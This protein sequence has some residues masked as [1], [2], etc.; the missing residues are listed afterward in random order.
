MLYNAPR[1]T[2]DI[3]PDE[4]R[5]WQYV[6]DKFRSVCDRFAYEEIRIPTFEHTEV[7]LR[8][9]GETTDVVQKEMYT[10]DDKSGR[11][12]TLR[13]EGTA[14]VAR[15]FIEQGMSSN[16]YPVR[17]YYLL[18]LFRYE[19]VGKGRYREFNQFGV[20][21]FGSG[22]PDMDAEVIALADLF[23]AELG[24]K[25]RLHINSIGCPE[26][27]GEYQKLLYEYYL[28]H[29]AELCPDC[30]QRLER[31]PLRLIDC[32]VESCR[33]ISRS[34]PRLLDYLDE[35]CRAHFDRVLEF[36]RSL[37]IEY[38]IDKD[39]V[40]GLDYYTKTVF[41]FVS[42][43]VGTQGTICGGGRY[44][45]LI[46]TMGGEEVPGVGFALGVER[47]LMELEAQGCLPELAQYPDLFIA[48]Q[49]E[50]AGAAAAGLALE[51]RRRG[52]RV[53]SEVCG[54]SLRA[55]LKQA[56]RSAARWV[57]VLGG[58]ELETGTAE[59][60]QME[61]GE[62]LTVN[63]CDAAAVWQEIKENKDAN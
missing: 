15:S 48:L 40:R 52:L 49:T 3:L 53:V 1:G 38:T 28:P 19:R 8:S 55:Q 39:I 37:G 13:P 23:F 59:L 26:C 4:T 24:L 32:K 34:A 7:F 27:R 12:L 56:D 50:A 25:R 35:D 33:A 20:E 18:N 6:E 63:W 36:L 47:L 46:E 21:A 14:G 2:R 57:L 30:Q 60:R 42:E 11:S 45:T 44:D 29:A 61:S 17:L 41:E 51:L 10:F 54:R 5:L 43:N 31:N 62:R 22:E 16:P 58:N 9:V